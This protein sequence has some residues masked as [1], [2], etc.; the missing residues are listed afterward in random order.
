MKTTKGVFVINT[1]T[2]AVQGALVVM[3]GMPLAVQAQNAEEGATAQNTAAAVPPQDATDDEAAALKRPTNFVEIGALNVSRDSAKFGEYNGLNKSGPYAIGNFSVRGGDAYGDG[4]GTLRWGVKGT[5]L[6]TT[7]RELGANVANQGTWNLGVGYDEL[8]HNITDTYSTPFQGSMGGNR[9][10]LPTSFGV[11]NTAAPGTDGLTV[12]QRQSLSP[13]DV[14]SDRKN[15]SF[16]AGYNFDR[17]WNVKL[18]FNHLEQ[19]GAKLL[20]VAGEKVGGAG[21][22]GISTWAGQTPMV[23]MNPTNYTTDTLNLA[24][25]WVGEKGYM[26]AAYFGSFFRDNNNS[27]SFSNPFQTTKATGFAPS[28]FPQQAISTMPSNDFHQ[29]NL[30]GGYSFSPTTK[31]S[32]GL[33]YGRNTQNDAYATSVGQAFGTFPSSLQGLVVSTHADLKLTNQTTKDLL[34][35]AGFKYNERDNQTASN[36]YS[37][38]HIN[39]FATPGQTAV[40][41]PMSNKK[42]QLELAGDYRINKDQKLR[43]SYEYEQIKRW[44]NNGVANSG[45]GLINFSNLAYWGGAAY[46][47]TTCAEVPESNENKLAANY[48][49]K[50]SDAVNFN[51]GYGYS[52]RK[53]DIN[54]AFYNPMQTEAGGEGFEVPGFVSYFQASRREQLLKAGANWQPTEKLSL[55]LTGRFTD[56]KYDDLTYGVQNGHSWSLNLDATYSYSE[57]SS[58]SAY[59][60]SQNSTRDLTNL[61]SAATKAGLPSASALSLPVGATW[62]NKLNENDMTFGLGTRKAGLM[63]G[64]LDLAGDLTYSIGKTGY[65]TQFNYTSANTGGSTC[66]SAFYLTCGDLP[67]INNKLIALKLTGSYKVDKASRVM[68]GYMYQHLTSNDFFYNA[69]QVGATPTTLLPTN[70]QAPN[71]NA[72]VVSVTYIYTF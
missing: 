20:G 50:V 15:T 16:T 11:I 45:N 32:G 46:S 56:D 61:Q 53:S 22:G 29:L 24:A 58:V 4:N 48:K 12:N 49:L 38:D 17:Q 26:T 51:A 40:N 43:L 10:T 64:K 25:N 1:L 30:T 27:L 54:P 62:T 47:A 31:L 23:L 65:G 44:C 36:T 57:D 63:N 18:D 60:T 68:L 3:L 7:S 59:V 69:Y 35:S 70:Q 6:G 21:V 8:S 66:S 34:L 28:A 52:R 41:A 72:N 19:S 39:E 13:Q 71:Y 2:L 37:W 9:F 55:G 14:H 42:T 5:D 67:D 33:S